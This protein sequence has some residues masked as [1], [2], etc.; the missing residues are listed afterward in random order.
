MPNPFESEESFRAA[1]PAPF[2]IFMECYKNAWFGTPEK[3]GG[4]G[5]AGADLS[6]FLFPLAK[7]MEAMQKE[8]TKAL[9]EDIYGGAPRPRR[10]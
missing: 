10:R 7:T 6:P 8:I 9:S 5:G 4:K 1:M 2:S 3:G